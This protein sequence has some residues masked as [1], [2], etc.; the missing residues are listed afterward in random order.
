ML[1]FVCLF[2][3]VRFMRKKIFFMDYIKSHVSMKCREMRSQ[4]MGGVEEKK[5]TTVTAKMAEG[6]ETHVM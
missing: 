3:S 2:K 1:L 4:I 6:T 5:Y